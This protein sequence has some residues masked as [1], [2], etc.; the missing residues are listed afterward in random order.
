VPARATDARERVRRLLQAKPDAIFNALHGA[1]LARFV[2]EARAQ[3][4]F[5]TVS[6]VAPL[7]G[8]PEALHAMGNDAEAGWLVSG[9]PCEAADADAGRRFADD[10]LA[11]WGVAPGANSALGYI[12]VKAIAE[13]LS[14]AGAV[15]PH[16]LA[17]AFAGL[18]LDTPYGRIQ[19]RALDHQSTLGVCLGTTAEEDGRVV[20]HPLSYLDGARLQPPDK[21][22]HRLT[23]PGK[24]Q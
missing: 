21:V 17:D 19:F 13:G 14:K 1:E 5:Q 7:A 10:Y 12:A 6:V 4:L 11:R 23:V 3:G 2:H 24:Q 8:Q 9:Y 18:D 20:V 15:A 16:A 22:V